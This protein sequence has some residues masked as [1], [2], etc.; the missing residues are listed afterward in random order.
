MIE[1][2]QWEVSADSKIEIEILS[3]NKDMVAQNYAFKKNKCEREEQM[4]A[5]YIL[6]KI[7]TP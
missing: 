6:S 5:I 1:P 7:K 3:W 2:K 4:V